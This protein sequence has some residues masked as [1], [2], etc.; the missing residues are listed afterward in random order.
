MEAK[1]KIIRLS[2]SI[3]RHK[4]LLESY[5]KETNPVARLRLEKEISIS[6]RRI[7]QTTDGINLLGKGCFTSVIYEASS[8][9]NPIRKQNIL[10]TFIGL[11]RE[12][13]DKILELRSFFNGYSYKILDFLETPTSI[14]NL[15]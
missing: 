7:K 15:Y 14:K 9:A 5:K 12:D 10:E 8:E 1:A 13:I 6:K 4:F 2:D 3:Q 11:T